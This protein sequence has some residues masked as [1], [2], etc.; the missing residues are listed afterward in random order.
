MSENFRIEV[1]RPQSQGGQHVGRSNDPVRVTHIP[2]GI[3]AQ[4]GSDRSQHRNRTV[5]MEMVEW[6]LVSLGLPMERP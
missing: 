1:I 2:T 4:C 3:F 5:A 6:A